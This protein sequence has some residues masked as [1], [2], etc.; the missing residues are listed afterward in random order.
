LA[1]SG[2]GA[3]ASAVYYPLKKEQKYLDCKIPL[4]LPKHGEKFILVIR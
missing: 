3:M 2:L 1:I 4:P